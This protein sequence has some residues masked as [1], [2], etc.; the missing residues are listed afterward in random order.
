MVELIDQLLENCMT[1]K[2]EH[3]LSEEELQ[4]A[5]QQYSKQKSLCKTT[6]K[7]D[8]AGL[9]VEMKMSFEEWLQIWIS[10]GKYHLRG[11]RKGCY[12]MSR[13]DD[14]GHYA[15]DN[16]DIIP[17]EENV[18]FAQS[19]EKSTLFGKTVEHASFKG[20]T[21]A[22]SLATGKQIFMDGGKAIEKAGFDPST[23]YKC[24]NG[25]Y[26]QHLGHRFHRFNQ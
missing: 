13:K 22:T 6:D 2:F 18:Q 9:P 24:I 23:V 12:V 3:N 26:K 10:S 25:K 19:G 14:L 8:A 1:T 21:V 17:Q 15:V 7:R 20:T 5:R 11:C 16:V 4:E